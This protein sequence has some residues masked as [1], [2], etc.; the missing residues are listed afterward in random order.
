MLGQE[1]EISIISNAVKPQ[2]KVAPNVPSS[3]FSRQAALRSYRRKVRRTKKSFFKHAFI[4]ANIAL[5]LVVTGVVWTGQSKS[6]GTK[7]LS[8]TISTSGT[9]AVSSPLDQISSADIAANIANATQLPEASN[10][11]EQADS[12]SIKLASAPVEES[13]IVKPQLVA[14]GGKSRNDIQK[15]TAVAGDTLASVAAKFGITSDSIR[16]SNGLTSNS[17]P[18]G[19]E[20]QIPPRN[21]IVY[22]VASGD[23]IDSLV[24]RYSANKE[25]LI[26]FNDIELSGL[27]VGDTIVIPDGV[28]PA[29]PTYSSS[30]SG[31]SISAISFTA[32]Y[33]NNTYARGFCT[34]YAASR[35]NIPSNWGNA[36]TWDDYA[37]MSGWTVSGVPIPGAIFQT[38]AGWAGHVGYVE[39]VSPDGSQVKVSDMNGIAGF[40]RVGYSNWIPAST[41]RYIYR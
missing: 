33:G 39:A 15:Y 8:N 25:Q 21:G 26:A 22:K 19:K 14:S 34:W 11:S 40:G 13:V 12:Y 7:S 9:Q 6:A 5:I 4:L 35:V 10:V 3:H 27:T 23:T 29:A 20:L 16:W 18:A 32:L 36:N 41:Y 2:R 24:S 28:K 37:R 31:Y 30:N 17:I 38:D 1:K